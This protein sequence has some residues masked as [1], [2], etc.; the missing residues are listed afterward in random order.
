[1]KKYWSDGAGADLHL[2]HE[3]TPEFISKHCA[4]DLRMARDDVG[5]WSPIRCRI[6]PAK[7]VAWHGSPLARTATQSNGISMLET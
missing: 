6:D 4:V 1:M 2:T 3:V 5:K 7:L